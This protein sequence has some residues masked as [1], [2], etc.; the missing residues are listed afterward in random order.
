MS[1]CVQETC[2]KTCVCEVCRC[3][4]NWLSGFVMWAQGTWQ[5][6]PC[7]KVKTWQGQP[8]GMAGMCEYLALS[9]NN[10][11]QSKDMGKSE[12]IAHEVVHVNL[13]QYTFHVGYR[14]NLCFVATLLSDHF[15][16]A[17]CLLNFMHPSPTIAAFIIISPLF[18]GHLWL[19][20]RCS[21]V[22]YPGSQM[23]L[24]GAS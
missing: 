7:Y 18:Y 19:P 14:L 23:A 9:C 8:L 3:V 2:F 13:H 22:M 1:L 15:G 5:G 10:L 4:N 17:L 21:S 24:C 6:K 16:S 20:L 12:W 11:H